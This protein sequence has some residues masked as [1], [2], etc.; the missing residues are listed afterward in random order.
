MALTPDTQVRHVTCLHLADGQPW[1][2]EERWINLSLLPHAAS[3]DFVSRGPTEWLMEQIPF[4][5]VEISISATAA[6]AALA[7]QLDCATGAPLLMTERMTRWNDQ[8][9][10]LAR[11]IHRPGHRMT[12]R[13]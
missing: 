13:Y 7:R 8:T 10:T 9:V 5:A 2:H 4:S 6:D 11:L 3:A 12:T 1:L